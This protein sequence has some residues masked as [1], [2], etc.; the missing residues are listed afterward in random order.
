MFPAPSTTVMSY[1]NDVGR[2]TAVPSTTWPTAGSAAG[3][4][5]LI[6]YCWPFEQLEVDEEGVVVGRLSGGRPGA[7][8]D[9]EG[10]GWD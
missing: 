6:V 1:W 10:D 5:T 8:R 3:S 2:S 7:Q 4:S 9:S